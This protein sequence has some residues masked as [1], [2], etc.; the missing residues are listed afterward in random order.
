[1]SRRSTKLLKAALAAVHYSGAESLFA[2]FTQGVGVIY[3]LHQVLPD[4]PRAFGPSRILRV[5]PDFLNTVIQST[6]DAGFDIISIEAVPERLR[7]GGDRPFAVFTLDDGY[8]DNRA[9]AYPIFR[10]HSVPFTIYV[11]SNFADGK[12]HL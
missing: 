3:M 12:P 2:P 4:P 7:E 11:A 6:R 10:R 5:T 1:M 9:F 8:R